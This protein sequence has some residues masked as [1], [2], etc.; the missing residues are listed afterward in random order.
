MHISYINFSVVNYNYLIV[1]CIALKAIIKMEVFM[2]NRS[3]KVRRMWHKFFV[4]E[5]VFLAWL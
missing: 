4:I 2:I 3:A 1:E 5:E